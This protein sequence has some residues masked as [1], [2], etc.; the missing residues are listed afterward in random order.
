[1]RNILILLTLCV[2]ALT[3]SNV[4]GEVYDESKRTERL[5]LSYY[6]GRPLY[7]VMF[8]YTGGSNGEPSIGYSMAYYRMYTGDNLDDFGTN[9]FDFYE[10]NGRMATVRYGDTKV[11]ER[12]FYSVIDADGMIVYAGNHPNYT[13]PYV[14]WARDLLMKYPPPKYSES[15]VAVDIF[16]AML[17][18]LSEMLR[19]WLGVVLAIGA[20]M[21]GW[22]FIR[23]LWTLDF[24]GK[25][26]G[27]NG[28]ASAPLSYA[29]L[30]RRDRSLYEDA[31]LGSIGIESSQLL[32]P[33]E[34]KKDVDFVTGA[35]FGLK[36]DEKTRESNR[37]LMEM[38]NRLSSKEQK[39]ILKAFRE[40]AF[41]K[42]FEDSAEKRF[43]AY[44][45]EVFD[46][47]DNPFT[48]RSKRRAFDPLDAEVLS[49]GYGSEYVGWDVV[50]SVDE[51]DDA[52][53]SLDEAYYDDNGGTP[54]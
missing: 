51:I 50:S 43:L 13:E 40:S 42:S 30:S 6:D 54:F 3:T 7:V 23:E 25:P 34:I 10:A 29:K 12:Y 37:L 14:G 27:K 18:P 35:A 15:D 47:V 17:E 19:G 53:A 45:G 16:D 48:G 49:Q 33:K 39:A 32:V 8:G 41:D 20:V 24:S 11:S 31:A 36:F 1:M 26:K 22:N 21:F 9:D 5:G 52:N 2:L 38:F 28:K 46:D 4:F 44:Q